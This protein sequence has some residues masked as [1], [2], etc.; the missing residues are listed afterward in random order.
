MRR[1]AIAVAV[2]AVIASST[3][4]AADA[5]LVRR[6]EGGLLSGSVNYDWW[7][8]CSP[9]SA[10]MLM[11]Y[12]DRNGYAGN[13]YNNLVP[14]G[15]AETNTFGAGPYLANSIIA[16]SG[17]IADFYAGGYEAENDDLP[18]SHSFDCL[19]DFMG[20][21][22][23]SEGNSNGGTTWW[24]YGDNSPVYESDVA[25]WL[26]SPDDYDTSGMYGI[27]EYLEYAGYD[28]AVLY[29]QYIYGY[30]TGPPAGFTLDQY[31]AEIDAGRPVLIHVEGHTM[32]G[33]GYVDGTTTINVYDTW[34][35]N[36][37]QNPG[38]M[39]WGGSYPYG[40]SSLEHYGVT[41]LEIIP[42]PASV[43][44]LLLGLSLLVS[45]KRRTRV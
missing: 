24:Y 20:T 12:Y 9:T 27:G 16:S 5:E 31:K 8:G 39:T 21:S 3:V 41:V 15:L 14:G 13:S 25:S 29:N 30:G 28:A 2:T 40:V 35:P 45:R 34:G 18:V 22:Q 23:D 11:G 38:T 7:Y 43:L 42:E 44:L 32:T 4:L 6:T 37:G 17:H 26:V 1:L 19:A 10:G 36:D 33:Y